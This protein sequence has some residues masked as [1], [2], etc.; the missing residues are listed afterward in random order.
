MKWKFY[1]VHKT[2]IKN[3][4]DL[5]KREKSLQFVQIMQCKIRKLQR[6]MY[7]GNKTQQITIGKYAKCIIKKGKKKYRSILHLKQFDMIN[8]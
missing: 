5:S 3:K 2:C 7:M 8:T 6:N 1:S 4:N